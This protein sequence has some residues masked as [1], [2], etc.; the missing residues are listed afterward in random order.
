[1]GSLSVSAH[2]LSLS[3]SLLVLCFLGEAA[4][5][6]AWASSFSP[7]QFNQQPHQFNQCTSHRKLAP[8][9]SPVHVSS[10][11]SV[12]Q[13]GTSEIS[14]QTSW[15]SL[16]T[17]VHSFPK[18]N[19]VKNQTG[20]GELRA[21]QRRL[22]E[23]CP[24]SWAEVSTAASPGKNSVRQRFTLRDFDVMF[25]KWVA[26]VC[27]LNVSLWPWCISPVP[28]DGVSGWAA[29]LAIRIAK[30]PMMISRSTAGKSLG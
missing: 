16:F 3:C 19:G 7:H 14:Q 12:G 17:S 27:I 2:R 11:C 6:M 8:R 28:D 10:P 24:R 29:V 23:A 25:L 18:A 30:H 5:L 15:G 1:M 20:L 22:T 13:S 26:K 4:S 9:Q 21:P